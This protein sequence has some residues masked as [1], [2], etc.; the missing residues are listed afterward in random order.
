MPTVRGAAEVKR[1]IAGLPAQLEAKVL[2]GAARAA[3]NVVADEARSR[4][5][6]PDVT[7]AIKVAVKVEDGRVVAKVQVK[8][9][10]AYMA[11][12]LEYGTAP[13]FISVD[14]SQRAGRSAARINA[15]EQEGS[16]LIA[17]ARRVNNEGP[18]GSIVIGGQ[19]VGT[20]VHHPGARAHPFLRVS[21]DVKEAE[22]LAAA[23]S[24]ISARVTRAGISGIVEGN[25]A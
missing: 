25:D 18:K 20:T 10:G 14:D 5:I 22:A 24:Y 19:F 16:A 11:P 13:H 12:W 2:R 4:S 21:L 7:G 17:G 23:Q 1:F 3:A 8:G 6:S 15:L 9:Q